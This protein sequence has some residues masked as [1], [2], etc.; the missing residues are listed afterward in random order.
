MTATGSQR[1]NTR[2]LADQIKGLISDISTLFRQE[3]ELA[4]TE[5]GERVSS[6]VHGGQML[7]IGAILAIGALGVLLAGIVVAI[8]GVL[9]GM[10]MEPGLANTI[11]AVIVA[12]VVGGIAWAMISSGINKLKTSNFKMEKTT[13]SL[14]AD[15]KVVKERL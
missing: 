12:V 7:V 4:K 14:S 11:A 5:A 2:G 9:E 6:A 1:E 15:A 10:G 13:H 8:A 3:I